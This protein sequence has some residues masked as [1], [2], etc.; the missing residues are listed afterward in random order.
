M[1]TLL[2]H[3]LTRKR[4][5]CALAAATAVMVGSVC[6]RAQAPNPAG[7]NATKHGIAVVDVSYIFKEHTRFRATMDAMKKEM[8]VALALT[9]VTDVR[10]L[11]REALLP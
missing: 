10:A 11:T 5:E 9:G 4:I 6:A 1:R 2:H 3:K 8:E 7:A